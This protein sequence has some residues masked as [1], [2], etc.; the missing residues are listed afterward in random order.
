MNNIQKNLGFVAYL[1]EI[2]ISSHDFI[3]LQIYALNSYMENPSQS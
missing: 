1:R 2:I 3:L